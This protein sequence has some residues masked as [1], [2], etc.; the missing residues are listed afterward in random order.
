MNAGG[1]THAYLAKTK[2][3]LPAALPSAGEDAA[4]TS[5]T[6]NPV[7]GIR[8]GGTRPERRKAT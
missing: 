7:R 2:T 3:V 5:L 8:I 6:H 4:I 1:A